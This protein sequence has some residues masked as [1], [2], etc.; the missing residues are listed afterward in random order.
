MCFFAVPCVAQVLGA[1]GAG[2]SCLLK[3]VAG[4]LARNKCL[5]KARNLCVRACVC[6]SA[7]AVC[8]VVCAS[9]S[10]RRTTP[11]RDVPSQVL[12][13]GD[14]MSGRSNVV[15]TNLAKMVE[16]D[17]R[18]LPLLTVRETLQFAE[19]FQAA[20]S[21]RGERFFWRT[22]AHRC[23]V[24]T[25]ARLAAKCPDLIRGRVLVR[26]YYVRLTTRARW[27]RC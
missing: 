27:T 17:D 4:Q 18:H 3:A 16:Q 12:Y 9:S 10:H 15:L 6:V 7:G 19:R 20:P 21:V 25:R 11:S 24:T 2:K 13:N 1:P 14:D 22:H 5:G 23:S 26:V 8:A